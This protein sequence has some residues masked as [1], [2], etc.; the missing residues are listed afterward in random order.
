ME[1]NGRYYLKLLGLAWTVFLQGD[2]QHS[3]KCIASDCIIRARCMLDAEGFF[4]RLQVKLIAE[5]FIPALYRVEHLEMYE[6]AL[7]KGRKKRK[8]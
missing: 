1:D 2:L 5:N 4:S 6:L 8:R 7:L 3:T